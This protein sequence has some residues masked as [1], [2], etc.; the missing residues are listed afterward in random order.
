MLLFHN[1][2]DGCPEAGPLQG[3]LGSPSGAS[4]EFSGALPGKLFYRLSEQFGVSLKLFWELLCAPFWR[5]LRGAERS[6]APRS[7]WID[8]W[9]D[10]NQGKQGS[11]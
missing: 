10:H 1:V 4:G 3:S 8:D 2:S 5:E 9:L 7:G 11:R 6:E